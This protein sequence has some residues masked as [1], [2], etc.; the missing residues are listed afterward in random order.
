M[1]SYQK[2]RNIL[3]K[4]KIKI[5]NEEILVKNSLNRVI[6]KNIVSPSYHPLA[7]NAA[8]DGFVINSNDTKNASKKNSIFFK[9]IGSIAAGSKPFKKKTKKYEAVEIMTGGLLP[10]SLDTIIPIEKTTFYPNNKYP[11]FIKISQRVK[12]NNHIR[13]KGSDYK[14]GQIIIRKGTIIQPNH[15]MALETLG[16]KKIKVKK[17]INILFFSTGNEISNSDKVNDWEVRNSNMHYIKSVKKNFLFNFRDGG[18][19]R[20]NHKNVFEKKIK[21]IMKSRIN[22]ILTT[23][24]VSAGKFDFIPSI[25]K[26]FT[27]SYY[28]KSVRIR[29]GKPVLF[30][31]LGKKVIFGLPGN[32]LSTAACFRFLVYPFIENILEVRPERPFKAIL[33]NSFTKKIEFTRFIKSKFNTTKNGKILIKLLPGQESYRINPFAESNVWAVLPS[34]ISR[35]KKGQIIDCFLPNQ[36][37]KT[38]V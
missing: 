19:L 4:S 15:I 5:L 16:I 27:S 25:V 18:I 30:A 33:K 22:I 21:K 36:S 35:F 37:N 11:K 26:K 38:L 9:I 2:A 23:G 12:K 14:K 3:K 24:A 32:P 31:K 10:K 7:D 20:D 6:A 1:I 28:F 13:F 34:G 8:F 29:P 17:M